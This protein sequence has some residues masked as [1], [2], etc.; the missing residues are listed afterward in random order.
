M[1]IIDILFADDSAFYVIV[2]NCDNMNTRVQ[3]T[4]KIIDEVMAAFGQK[5]NGAKTELSVIAKTKEDRQIFSNA[6]NVTL[7]EKT[8]NV[9]S[10]FKYVGSLVTSDCTNTEEINTRR[11]KMEGNYKT[12]MA[13]MFVKNRLDVVYM[14]TMFKVFIVSTGTFN[15]SAWSA[16]TKE[17]MSLNVTARSIL[18]RIFGFKWFHHVS[19]DYLIK[20]CNLMGCKMYPMHLLVKMQRLAFFGHILRMDDTSL[21]KKLLFG[22]IIGG[23]RSIGRPSPRWIDRIYEDLEDFGLSTD[24]PAVGNLALDRIKWRVAVKSK[25]IELAY[26]R[27]LQD[28]TNRTINRMAKEGIQIITPIV[29]IQSNAESSD[30]KKKSL[31][32]LIEKT[33]LSRLPY[34]ILVNII[35]KLGP[36]KSMEIMEAIDKVKEGEKNRDMDDFEPW[37]T[38]FII[39]LRNKY[40]HEEEL[41]AESASIQNE[42]IAWYE[43]SNIYDENTNEKEV[44]HIQSVVEHKFVGR[45]DCYRVIWE[46]RKLKA[47]IKF[48]EV[49][50]ELV[51]KSWPFD[52]D[53]N[54]IDTSSKYFRIMK[55]DFKEIM[56][57]LKADNVEMENLRKNAVKTNLLRCQRL[58]SFLPFHPQ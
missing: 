45:N 27:W 15:C 16:G 36:E 53:W 56:E 18:L 26:Q 23:S 38:P 14:I 25:G 32:K 13:N 57:E 30:K 24:W 43:N 39:E 17:L 46:P 3:N 58:F 5:V 21:L 42:R 8:L 37:S 6:L 54:W 49:F 52:N 7:G 31:I 2:N 55:K 12:H 35:Q 4:I 29:D 50:P 44:F 33:P 20:L 41:A 48:P 9:V 1:Y 22:E 34:K 51:G 19:Y 11:C 28:N 47:H 10:K 40:L